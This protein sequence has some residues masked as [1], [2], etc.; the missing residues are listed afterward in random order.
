MRLRSATMLSRQQQMG[1]LE[2]IE[3]PSRTAINN[4]GKLWLNHGSI[5][6]DGKAPGP[7]W[8]SSKMSLLHRIAEPH[9]AAC[10]PLTSS[11]I[12]RISGFGARQR[13]LKASKNP[14][15][16]GLCDGI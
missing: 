1:V 7:H 8:H 9:S 15:Q 6:R 5:H 10:K 4:M 2:T 12:E 16:N 11:R 14:S 3:P 13:V